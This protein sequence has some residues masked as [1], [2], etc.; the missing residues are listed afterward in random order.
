MHR[1]LEPVETNMY[2]T[3][4]GSTR[5]MRNTPPKKLPNMQAKRRKGPVVK[6]ITCP[7]LLQDEDTNEIYDLAHP[8]RGRKRVSDATFSA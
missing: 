7:E 3:E 5:K 2:E 4:R 6:Q 1:L 8:R